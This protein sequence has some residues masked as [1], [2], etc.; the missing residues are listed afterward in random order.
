MRIFPKGSRIFVDRLLEGYTKLAER[1]G[2]VLQMNEKLDVRA[3]IFVQDT[4]LMAMP[5]KTTTVFDEFLLAQKMGDPNAVRIL[6]EL[7][8]RY[9]SPDELLG[10]F[11]FTM[12]TT[13]IE[14][15]KPFVWPQNIS[16][17]TRYKLIG[18]SV[19][20]FVVSQLINYLF[21]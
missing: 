21:R 11:N 1:A 12:S 15:G 14:S 20:V 13:A 17:K 16:T 3:H 18:N 7:R 9:F 2:S 5:S 10:L 6:D 8:L 19:N 4:S